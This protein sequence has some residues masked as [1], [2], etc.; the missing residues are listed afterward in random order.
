MC[1]CNA[2]A[3]F[4]D[5]SDGSYVFRARKAGV[6][7]RDAPTQAVSVFSVDSVP[8]VVEVRIP[9]RCLLFAVQILACSSLLAG[10]RKFSSHNPR[11]RAD[12]RAQ[13]AGG[14][15]TCEGSNA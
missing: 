6:A 3:A 12:R 10:V 7:G 4:D 15:M 9:L 13:C 2:T 1:R 14:V 11:D 8:P 5:L